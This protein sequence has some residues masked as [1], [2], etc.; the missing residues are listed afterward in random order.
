MTVT[1][2][3]ASSGPFVPNG[4]TTAFPYTFH[5]R[6]G[7][8]LRVVIDG[9]T[10]SNLLYT[11][12]VDA[13]FEGG[14]VNFLTAPTGSAL[15]I[16]SEPSFTQSIQ[17]ENSG[18]FLPETHD[19]AL[20]RAAVRIIFLK[21]RS[22]RSIRAPVGET[23][24][25][26]PSIA[27]RAGMFLAFGAGGHPVAAS[28][29]GVDANLR[30]D[31]ALASGA[32]L[33]GFDSGNAYGAGSIGAFLKSL[34][35]SAG[36][37][38]LGFI[39]SGAGAVQRTIAAKLQDTIHVKDYGAVCDGV[40][41]DTV[42]VQAAITAG[43]AQ[44][45]PVIFPKT[46]KLGALTVP[47]NS[48]LIGPG[49]KCTVTWIAGTYT[50]FTI[51]GSDVVI[52]G[53]R[54]EA[55]L[56]TGGY[57]YDINVGVSQYER[58]T[59]RDIVTFNARGGL[60][61]TGTTGY[62]TTTVVDHVQFR[63]H[64]GPGVYWRRSFAFAQFRWVAVDFVGVATSDYTGFDID[65]SGLGVGAG[66][67]MLEECDVLGTAGTFN[68]ANQH[69]Y[70]IANQSAVWFKNTRAD[71]LGGKGYILNALNKCMFDLEASLCANVGV[72]MTS[73]T[74]SYGRVSVFGRAGL[75]YAPANIDAIQFVSGCAVLKL[76]SGICRD[77]TRHGMHKAAAQAGAI[78]VTGYM[79]TNNLGRGLVTVGN[80]AFL[81]TGST[82]VGNTV[83]NYDLGGGFDYIYVTQLNSGAVVNAGPGP[84]SA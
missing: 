71:T 16:R 75:A 84:V 47:A 6:A 23:M 8:E 57:E 48:H 70:N 28:G 62:H 60:R 15:Y 52:E 5:A 18:P 7:S 55:A 78:N 10:V 49:P 61:D 19:E 33:L 35:A 37:T 81:M 12:A 11:V 38:L 14:T 34:I 17:F 27:S 46:I 58:I 4:V 50:S 44:G 41:D 40:A 64:N 66:G 32:A 82:M 39:H 51:N 29:T 72:E 45:K 22:D 80:S 36:A 3:A 42:A 1:S 24:D 13:D 73:V 83:G 77:A 79:L 9:A 20:D 26:L 53:F 69:G 76:D 63:G 67:L 25:D 59:L 65:G 56:K 30:S 21:D 43:A 2:T 74:N 54:H 68:L 31:M